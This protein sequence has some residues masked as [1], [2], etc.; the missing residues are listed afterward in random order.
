MKNSADYG[1]CYPQRPKA[2]VDNSLRCFIISV[3]G[4]R[5]TVNGRSAAG[6]TFDVIGSIFGQ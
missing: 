1:G 2:E 4:Q 5:S 6:C 3:N